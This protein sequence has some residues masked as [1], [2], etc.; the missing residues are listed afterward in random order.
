[1]MK[2]LTILTV[3]T[4]S[5]IGKYIHKNLGGLTITRATSPAEFAEI[6]DRGVDIIIHCARSKD[7]FVN[8]ETLYNYIDDS[9]FLTKRLIDIP[10]K[11][12][13]YFSSV[14]AYAK[15]N[16]EHFESEVIKVESLSSLYGITKLMSEAIIRECCKNFLII[17]AATLLGKE[18]RKNS[19]MQLFGDNNCTLTLSPKSMFNC[20]RYSDILEFIKYA[21]NYDLAGI[22]NASCSQ[23][24]ILAD[25]AKILRAEP[26][27]GTYTYNIGS[28]NNAKITEIIPTFKRTSEENIDFFL[29]ELGQLK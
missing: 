24:I 5:G 4:T 18:M 28:I 15:N 8:S 26:N 7:K 13:I 11:K 9:L 23:N 27:F 29:K 2:D 10:H 21:I 25:I 14:E 19:F 12:F 3:G 20:V 22:Y 16:E 1:M 17:R 6:K